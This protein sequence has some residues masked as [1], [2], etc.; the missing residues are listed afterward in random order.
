M[1]PRASAREP[2]QSRRRH[3]LVAIVGAAVLLVTGLAAPGAGAASSH[4]SQ[5]PD[6]RAIA[7]T[8]RLMVQPPV[9]TRAATPGHDGATPRPEESSNVEPVT[10][11]AGGLFTMVGVTCAPA[12][13]GGAVGVRVR[14]SLDG[15][16]WSPWYEGDLELAAEAD[17]PRRAF[18]EATWTG[19][20]RYVQLAATAV[21]AARPPR[22]ERRPPGGNRHRTRRTAGGARREGSGVSP[23]RRL[24]LLGPAVSAAPAQPVIISRAAWGADESLRKRGPGLRSRAHGLHPSHGRR[25]HVHER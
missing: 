3:E 13:E 16:E 14:T 11:D 20:G 5:T 2:G 1:T 15:H 17:G 21:D 4:V 12:D 22:A 19:P 9:G 8:D 18:L 10:I 24:T 25:Q 6:T 23:R 7:V